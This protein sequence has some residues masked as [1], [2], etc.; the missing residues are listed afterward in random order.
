[1]NLTELAE[2]L[3]DCEIKFD[4][5]FNMLGMATSQFNDEKIL[6]FIADEQY[7]ED[8]LS[9]D[10]IVA[11]VT[12]EEL[13]KKIILPESYGV[14]ISATPKLTFYQIHNYLCT[15]EFYW[16]HF[17]NNIE[18]NSKISENACIASRNVIIGKN[19]IIEDDVV[20]HEGVIIGDNVI[21]RSGSQI[22]S[23]GFQFLNTKNDVLSVST[24]GRVVIKNNVEI[25]HNTC[26]DSGV[27]GGST[28]LSEYAKVDNLV[29]VAHDVYIGE[30]TFI[31]A[32]VKLGGRVRIGNDCWL[33]INATVSN[34]INI[35]NNSKISLGAVVT[36]D[37]REYATVSGNFAI[38]HSKFINFIKSI[39]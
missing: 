30:R 6:S 38:E 3:V 16:K 17:E 35:G 37:V 10:N 31:T 7:I 39:R 22:G 24:G 25:Q 29:H 12:S 36:K 27:L 21:I 32:G 4:A 15:I 2:V 8:V 13:I 9:N 20:I 23:K 19:S 33:G 11:I 28:I 34:G 1:M 26:V 14:I 5:E 18:K